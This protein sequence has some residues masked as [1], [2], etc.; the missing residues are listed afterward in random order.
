METVIEKKFHILLLEDNHDHQELVLEA[1]QHDP[2]QFRVSVAGT[3]CEARDLI[4]RDPPHLIIADWLLPD[5]KGLDILSC[6]NGIVTIPL[7]VMTSYGDETLAVE[8]MKSGAID[9][10]VKSAEMFRELPHISRR[11]IREWENFWERRVAQEAE[12]ATQKRLSDMLGFLPDAVL[13]IDDEGRVIAWNDAIERMTGVAAKDMLGKGNHEYSIPFYGERRP[14]LIDLVLMKDPEIEKKYHFIQRD[15]GR[16]TSE[17]FIPTLFD[18]KG[19]YLW[20]TASPLH[21]IHG[22]CVGAI[23]VI[24]DITARKQNEDLQRQ[25]EITL[26]TLLNAPSDTIDSS[27]PQGNNRRYKRSRGTEAWW[28]CPEYDREVRLRSS[29]T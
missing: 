1:F 6:V 23:E 13:A 24:R 4:E 28:C 17:T 18:G 8:I 7:I 19:A 29:S 21:D 3:V 22:K 15:G 2:V 10:V 25:R 27:R 11:A 20:G 26:K 5:G 14:I 12:R 16:I 9:Y